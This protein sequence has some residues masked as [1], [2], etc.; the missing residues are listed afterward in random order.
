MKKSETA[1]LNSLR[2]AVFDLHGTDSTW[3]KSV[4]VKELSGDTVVWEG[5]VE[6]FNLKN[7]ATADVAY[8]WSH[9]IEGST[10][11][12]FYVVLAMPPI[13]SPVKAV[14]AAIL[15]EHKGQSNL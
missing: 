3:I 15:Q 13:D 1:Y 9:P 14:R 10:K 8:A 5:S 7:H 11:H 2:K 4:E 6:L 12:K